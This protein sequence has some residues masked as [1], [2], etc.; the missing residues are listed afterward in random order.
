MSDVAFPL[1]H[2]AA[3]SALPFFGPMLLIV[4]FL[5]VSRLRS[6]PNSP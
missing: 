1:A 4:A 6:G 2:H 5:V 3:V